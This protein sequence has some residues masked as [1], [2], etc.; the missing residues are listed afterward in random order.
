ML[1]YLVALHWKKCFFACKHKIL[2]FFLAMSKLEL[3]FFRRSFP[4]WSLSK[5]CKYA[6][7]LEPPLP[8]PSH[9]SSDHSPAKSSV[10]TGRG[11]VYSVQWT[12]YSVHCT[13]YTVYCILSSVQFTLYIVHCTVY[14][15][16]CTLYSVQWPLAGSLWALS[17][18]CRL[19]Y[20]VASG[21]S[22]Q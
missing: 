11:S 2:K 3:L 9:L 20:A 5:Q 15:I 12:A 10:S 22:V 14:S 19:V 8:L 21:R 16:Q 18:R 17:S 6:H 13:L 4:N 1:S 7:T